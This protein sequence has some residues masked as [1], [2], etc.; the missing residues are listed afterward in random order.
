MVFPGSRRGLF[1][2]SCHFCDEEL[3]YE[4][5]DKKA[6]STLMRHTIDLHWEKI[7]KETEKLTKKQRAILFGFDEDLERI[8]AMPLGEV[9]ASSR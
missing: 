1:K 9:H 8:S 4:Q 5:D 6:E 2:V 3:G 7:T